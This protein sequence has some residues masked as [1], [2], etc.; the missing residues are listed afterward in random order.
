LPA[1][2]T[3]DILALGLPLGQSV[4]RLGC[5]MAGCCYGKPT[6]LPW[7]VT[8]THPETLGPLGV[9]VHPTQLYE[10]FL[11]LGVFAVLY[12]L[13]ARKQYD[14]QLVV[15]YFLLAGLVRFAVEFFR[16][17]PRGPALLAGM[18]STQ[19]LAL[20]MASVGAAFIIYGFLRRGEN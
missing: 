12:R 9:K 16:G 3:L 1:W 17:D 4:G 11:A 15:T 20:L 18:P 6:D 13:R 2:K 19:A 8:F 14:G 7:G 5:F 10:S